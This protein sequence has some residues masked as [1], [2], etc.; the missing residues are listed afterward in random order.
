MKLRIKDWQIHFENCESKKLK[1]LSWVPVP[2]KT[3]GEGYTDLVDHPDGAAHLGAW[4]A[5]IEA[6]STKEPRENRGLLPDGDGTIP[7]I[8]RSLG[9]I[10]RLPGKIFEEVL[11]RLL[12]IGWVEDLHAVQQDTATSGDSPEIAVD[13]P[14]VAVTKGR[15]GNR[16]EQNG[17]E[18]K[19]LCPTLVGQADGFSLNGSVPQGRPGKARYDENYAVWYKFYWNHNGKIP[20]RKAYEKAINRLVDRDHKTYGQ[21]RAFLIDEIGAYRGRFES[22]DSWSWRANLLPASWLNQELWTDEA[23]PVRIPITK[24]QLQVDAWDRA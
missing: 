23:E 2:N 3:N 18:E 4:L 8:S 24:Q 1:R 17:I 15:E 22:S 6:A 10:S 7:G 20:G 12:R 19:P 14:E 5:I 9:R 11:P 13:P 21:A 16:R